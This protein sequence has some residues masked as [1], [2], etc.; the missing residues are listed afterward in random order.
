MKLQLIIIIVLSI[1]LALS[2][3]SNVVLIV[4]PNLPSKS[5]L[6]SYPDSYDSPVTQ[7][8]AITCPENSVLFQ[9]VL[10]IFVPYYN[11]NTPPTQTDSDKTCDYAGCDYYDYV[12]TFFTTQLS[13]LQQKC[14]YDQIFNNSVTFDDT[15]CNSF[16][17]YSQ[18]E[19][20][21]Y[22]LF[23]RSMFDYI[24]RNEPQTFIM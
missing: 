2:I 23:L 7:N 10:D 24:A 8:I 5:S 1:L 14:V 16:S 18:E 9:E 20:D 22:C 3:A 15:F 19:L 17:G 13:Y 21:A 4:K 11:E 6:V 12:I